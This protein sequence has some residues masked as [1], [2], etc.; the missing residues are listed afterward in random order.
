MPEIV[1]YRPR[2]VP[3]VGK[4]VA[5]RMTQHVRMNR[6]RNARA[7]AGAG[8]YFSDTLGC[9]RTF[10]LTDEYKL[11]IRKLSSQ[12]P[13][14]PTFL[15]PQR[16]IRRRSILEPTDMQQLVLEVDLVPSQVSRLGDTQTMSIRDQDNRRIPQPVPA[17][18]FRRQPEFID[19]IRR[20]VL[21][22]AH[23]RVGHA[24]GR[25]FRIRVAHGVP[26]GYRCKRAQYWLHFRPIH[27]KTTPQL[28]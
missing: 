10:P 18:L 1:L 7:S 21:P 6:K 23:A 28:A 12:L 13:Q 16:M 22:G 26:A 24:R 11:R 9:Q 17:D 15:L 5:A 14:T 8:D 19:L 27:P 4:F 25:A 3:I 20:E 2:V